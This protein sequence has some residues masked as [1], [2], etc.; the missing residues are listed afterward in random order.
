[1]SLK[2]KSALPSLVAALAAAGLLTVPHKAMAQATPS[3]AAVLPQGHHVRSGQVE[4]RSTGTT[5]TIEQASLAAKLDWKRFDIAEGHTVRINQPGPHAFLVNRITGDT[6]SAINGSLI[7][8]GGV[9]LI[10]PHGVVFGRTA[11]VN[12]GSL[13]AWGALLSDEDMDVNGAPLSPGNP[14]S[15]VVN[16]G[17][18]VVRDGGVAALVAQDLR[19]A[20]GS[21]I[22]AP[23]GRVTL[24]ATDL[25]DGEPGS[26]SLLM[27]ENAPIHAFGGEVEVYASGKVTLGR[28][29]THDFVI[30]RRDIPLPSASAKGYDGR[31]FVRGLGNT[32]ALS[33]TSDSTLQLSLVASG[34]EPGRHVGEPRLEFR[35]W[36]GDVRADVVPEHGRSAVTVAPPSDAERARVDLPVFD[37]KLLGEASVGSVTD[38]TMTIEQHSDHAVLDWKSFNIA[39]D[40]GVKFV[41]NDGASTIVNRVFDTEGSRI[42]GR[43]EANGKVFVFNPN[44]VLLGRTAKVQIGGGGFLGFSLSDKQAMDPTQEWHLSSGSERADVRNEGTITI[45]GGGVAMLASPSSLVQAGLI[46]APQGTVNLVGGTAAMSMASQGA[47]AALT[48]FVDGGI[49]HVG[50]TRAPGGTVRA[51]ARAPEVVASG[52]IDISDGGQLEVRG[53]YGGILDAHVRPGAGIF[54]EGYGWHVP[55]DPDGLGRGQISAKRIS[56]WLEAGSHVHISTWGETLSVGAPIH[57]TGRRGARLT[58]ASG[59][60]RA[61]LADADISLGQGDLSFASEGEIRM[62]PDASISAKSGKVRFAAKEGLLLSKVKAKTLEIDVPLTAGFD[63]KDKV[64]DGTPSADVENETFKGLTL[65]EGSNLTLHKSYRFDSAALGEHTVKPKF[66]ISGFGDAPLPLSVRVADGAKN[67]ARIERRPLPVQNPSIW[68]SGG[69]QPRVTDKTMTVRQTEALMFIDWESFDVGAGHEVRFEQSSPDWWAINRVAAP[70][71]MTITGKVH[72][73][74]GLMFLVPGGAEIHRGATVTAGRFVMT[75]MTPEGDSLRKWASALPLSGGDD[76]SISNFGT[77]QVKEGGVVTLAS[78]NELEQGGTISAPKGAVHLAGVDHMTIQRDGRVL[79][80]RG[81]GGALS[82]LGETSAKEGDIRMFASDAALEGTIDAGE[83]GDVHL[84]GVGEGWSSYATLNPGRRIA[85]TDVVAGIGEVGQ[86]VDINDEVLAS[87]RVSRWLDDGVDVEVASTIEPLDA[88]RP[89]TAKAD[90]KGTLTLASPGLKLGALRVPRL[91]IDV[92]LAVGFDAQDKRFDGTTAAS[93][94]NKSFGNIELLPGSGLRFVDRYE[95]DS[96]DVGDRLVSA[97]VF[98][99]GH[100]DDAQSELQVA[101]P[102][103]SELQRH[104]ARILAVEPAPTPQPKPDPTPSPDPTPEP[105]PDPKPKPDPEP[106]PEPK[107]DPAPT[108][109]SPSPRPAPMPRPQ[110]PAVRA[111]V[112]C[113]QGRGVQG[114]QA[115]DAVRPTQPPSAGPALRDR[116]IR[117]PGGAPSPR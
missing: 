114:R 28:V 66:E 105:K 16:A 32:E 10:N 67:T 48:E 18:I 20:S 23:G 94:T 38:K 99:A 4:V 103:E 51:L 2:R 6:V 31:R 107:P 68:S 117:V 42:H 19:L 40:F 84:I 70:S 106:K 25:G 44:G 80:F 22:R 37:K 96:P 56:S 62:A 104:R 112:A 108:P 27:E 24:E 100:H 34:S 116:G 17:R 113:E 47:T 111:A 64:Y 15:Q 36:L 60:D 13:R 97:K 71:Q 91:A 87:T 1:M 41:Q 30:N 3:V 75:T 63:A 109:P 7:A 76:A 43:L 77:I 61:I 55:I 46:H 89:I 102:G 98:L 52:L 11:Q 78:S 93:V 54:V 58:L 57:A 45:T 79:N 74:A 83:K 90:A 101:A 33:F 12:V 53:F 88:S 35:D 86:F 65:N 115:C 92:P 9:Y 69:T 49:W 73:D 72:A 14:Q 21:S 29:Q 85:L 81:I 82:H 110:A 26:G 5:M 59:D 50:R 95:F 8:N 39:E